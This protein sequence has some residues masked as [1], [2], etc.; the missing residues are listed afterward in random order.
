MGTDQRIQDAV[1]AGEKNKKVMELVHNWCRNARVVKLGGTGM[2]EAAT[3]LPIGHHAMA[4][5]YAAAPGMGTWDLA[6]A[7]SRSSSQVS[8]GAARQ[9][10]CDG[11]RNRRFGRRT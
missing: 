5:D 3:G 9:V 8:L 1:T 7:A 10:A 4:C 2:V 11:C 6:E